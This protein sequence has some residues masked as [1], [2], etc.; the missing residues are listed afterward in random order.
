MKNNKIA[1]LLQLHGLLL[2]YS[3][4]EIFSKKASEEP[5]LSFRFCL[6]YFGIFAVLAV[7]AVGWQRIIRQIPLTQ[8]YANKAV[9]VIWG[10][11]WGVALFGEKLSVGKILG[12]LFVISGIVII[13]QEVLNDE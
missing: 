13:A 4:S 12:A 1:I 2:L 10:M 3:I 5:F 11:I 6:F 8:A 7:Y 9:T